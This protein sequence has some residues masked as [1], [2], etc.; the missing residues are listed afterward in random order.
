MGNTFPKLHQIIGIAYNNGQN[1]I[2][3]RTITL[4]DAYHKVTKWFLHHMNNLVLFRRYT[5]SLDILELNIFIVFSFLIT[6]GE[7][8][9]LK[10]ET[11]L[12]GVNNVIEWELLSLL[13]SSCFLHSLFR[14]CFIVGHVI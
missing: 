14:A 9:M 6:I 8:C 10:F 4:F 3:G 2:H 7:I 13:D 11:S 5:W 1:T 12:L